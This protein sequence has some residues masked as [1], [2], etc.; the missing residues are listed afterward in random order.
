MAQYYALYRQEVQVQGC[1]TATETTRTIRA[2]EPRTA[3]S[4]FIQLLSS[5][6]LF[7]SPMLLYVDRD[8]K[9][10]QG[11]RAQDVHLD[12]HTAPEL[13]AQSGPR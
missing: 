12:F 2:G 10:R 6:Y 4:T 8:D 7:S 11:W 13:Q 1:F 3:T 9:D 5:A